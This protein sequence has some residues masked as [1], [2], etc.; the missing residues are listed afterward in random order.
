MEMNQWLAGSLFFG[1]LSRIFAGSG[2]LA[3]VRGLARVIG[4]SRTGALFAQFL[5]KQYHG[6]DS[7]VGRW[8]VQCQ[9]SLRPLRSWW[10]R[11][12]SGSFL[13]DG[14]GKSKLASGLLALVIP[15]GAFY[16]FVDELGR[17]IFAG[18]S[19]FGYWDE[20]FMAACF[21][22]LVYEWLSGR[23]EKSG[24]TPLDAPLFLL[25]GVSFFLMINVG[26]YPDVAVEGF[27]VVIEY[28]LFY[29]IASRWLKDDKRALTLVGGLILTGA[30]LASHGFLQFL[31]KVQT[32]SSWTDQAETAAGPRVFSI[33]ESPNILGSIMMLLLPLAFAVLIMP[34]VKAWLRVA[35]TGV[36]GAMGLCVLLTQSRGAWFGLAVAMV[37]F[38][39]LV[40]PAWLFILAGGGFASLL[41]PQVYN[42]IAYLFTPAY[43][44]S[45]QRGGR[46]LR[47]ATGFSMF[48]ENPWT[49]VGLGHFGGAV[50]M[51][52]KNMFPTTFYMDSFWL[53]TLVEM[54]IP[55]IAAFA[56]LIGI[57]LI[58]GLRAVHHAAPGRDRLMA[59]GAFSGL[60]GVILHNF[61]ENIFEVPYMV[62]YFWFLAALLMYWGFGKTAQAR[63]DV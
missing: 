54:G 60:C 43:V 33:V 50:A 24:T 31:L 4:S 44:A 59:A 38:C 25:A 58:W 62:A 21:A 10:N 28:T 13:A 1:F 12:I 17:K 46:M 2:L 47:Y 53:K 49:G 45:S 41:V 16:V 6:E 5:D 42:R 27:R 35:L 52:H 7:L 15:F 26:R 14:V 8:S 37:V 11:L 29:F 55:G 32:P 56:L 63:A 34:N 30:A 48:Q 61:M 36:V 9:K 18:V 40:R 19:L 20:A 57:L 3:W 39:L 51:N 22:W 23:E